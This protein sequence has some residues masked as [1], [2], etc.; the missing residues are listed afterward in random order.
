[1]P[2]REDAPRSGRV[3]WLAAA[4]GLLGLAVTALAVFRW[5]PEAAAP[6]PS[7]RQVLERSRDDARRLGMTVAAAPR[8]RV[9]FDVE[10]PRNFRVTELDHLVDAER[11]PAARRRLLREFP[12][13]RR[14]AQFPAAVAADG[15]RGSLILEYGA[16]GRLIRVSFTA[17]ALSDLG[18]VI[19]VAEA[20]ALGGRVA[21][22]LL[23][24]PAP[25]PEAGS[26]V[27]VE[28]LY[29]VPGQ[30]SGVYV[31]VVYPHL[32]AA[33]WQTHAHMVSAE[34]L[35]QYLR[36][37]RLLCA[38]GLALIALVAI[39]DLGWRIVRRRVGLA[40][41]PIPLAVL[42]GAMAAAL[43]QR[44]YG[45]SL[46]YVAEP[47]VNW[48]G[49]VLA[50]AALTATALPTLVYS[51]AHLGSM[52]SSAL[53]ASAP[54]V[55]LLAGGWVAL[56]APER[57]EASLA[58]PAY[59]SRLEQEARMA[60]ELDLLRRLQL[61]MLPPPGA[62]QMPGID[63]AWRMTPADTI[64]GDLVD[65]FPDASGR[66]WIAVADAAGHG[67]SC[68]ILTATTRAAVLGHAV[69]GLGPAAALDAIRPLF[70]RLRGERTMV[71]LLLAVWDP[72][73]REL[74]AASAGHPPLLVFDGA[75][76]RELGHGGPPLGVH[77]P[78]PQGEGTEETLRAD[79][80]LVV[81]ASTDGVAETRSPAGEPYGFER[82]LDALPRA[83]GPP[84]AILEELL[85]DVARHR[86]Q[87]PQDD[88]TVLV[89][90]IAARASA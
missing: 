79:G 50:A 83:A 88:L 85:A 40:G 84:P 35:R 80:A 67:L 28:L 2:T 44:Y 45:Q 65:L 47:V 78:I 36:P 89:V 6:L 4:G 76:V 73:R 10:N 37:G 34:S 56:R 90:K 32:W 66:L 22:V 74:A 19:E 24:G 68:S 8:L 18:P 15:V 5:G 3:L 69:E 57:R 48:I 51:L 72:E 59:V 75:A 64:G 14:I 13:V 31:N 20:E 54:L 41:L 12:P 52:P 71:T 87:R 60:A 46:I 27:G 49:Y 1:M 17:A 55:L 23:G 70:L 81:V 61:A 86:G 26:F 7:P 25:E 33:R 58:R 63:A 9:G 16:A 29:R 77:L 42:G 21:S 53:A 11:D 62:P 82:W 30:S 43:G 38:A 39:G